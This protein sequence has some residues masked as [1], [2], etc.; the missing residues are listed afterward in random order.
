MNMEFRVIRP[1][2]EMHDEKAEK[3]DELFRGRPGLK[4]RILRVAADV[5]RMRIEAG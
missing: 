5:S 1:A 4:F 3:I 2:G